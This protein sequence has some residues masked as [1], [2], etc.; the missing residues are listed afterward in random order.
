MKTL[1]ERSLFRA[2]WR[3]NRISKNKIRK[4]LNSGNRLSHKKTTPSKRPPKDI[5]LSK[6]ASLRCANIALTMKSGG[7]RLR[8][9]HL[10]TAAR[11]KSGIRV[12]G[13]VCAP[14]NLSCTR[15]SIGFAR[16]K[17]RAPS[18]ETWL[19]IRTGK[20]RYMSR[21]KASSTITICARSKCPYLTLR[22]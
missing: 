10:G 21:R 1:R 14:T 22:I 7:A 11:A 3:G 15:S 5:S 4:I 20:R 17:T 9:T 6:R 19:Q 13:Q 18:P 16:T 12:R 8:T 2:R